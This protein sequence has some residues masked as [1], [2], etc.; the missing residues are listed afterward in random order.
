MQILVS[1]ILLLIILIFIFIPARL[2]IA[3]SRVVYV[4]G[5]GFDT[6][7]HNLEKWKHWWPADEENPGIDSLFI[8]KGMTCKLLTPYSDGASIEIKSG[9]VRLESRLRTIFKE[10]DSIVAEWSVELKS[11]YNPIKRL[12]NY[13]AG[14]KI[15][16]SLQVVFDSLCFFAG[17]TENIYGFPI[18]RTTFTEV[19]L[20]TSNFTS[21][22]Y[23]TTEMIYNAV[24]RLRQ[25]LVSKGTR[26]RYY[27]MMNSKRMDSSHVETMIAI[28]I[29]KMIPA[30]KDFFISQMVAMK[31]RFLTTDVTGGPGSIEKAKKSI[32]KYMTDHTLPAPARPFEILVT[33]RSKVADT[34]VWKTKI[35]YPSM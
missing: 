14:R 21:S 9:K 4:T 13:L 22:E 29:E 2:V 27:P 35:F 17:K 23:P 15:T 34:S 30:N 19:N 26:E 16:K 20:I 33:D 5:N 24:N 12:S 32:E 25:Y 7:L 8:Y 11:G 31:D 3:E 10:R 18:E 28:S 6:C 1:V